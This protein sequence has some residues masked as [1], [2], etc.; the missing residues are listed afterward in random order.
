MEEEEVE[1][2]K[3]EKEKV[4]RLEAGWGWKVGAK[5]LERGR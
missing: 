5:G 1:E 2:D 4:E 3:E